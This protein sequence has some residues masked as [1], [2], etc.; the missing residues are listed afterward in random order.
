[1][2][3]KNGK[4]EEE[5]K[6]KKGRK[7]GKDRDDND[8]EKGGET[9]HYLY[10]FGLYTRAFYATRGFIYTY[11]RLMSDSF[12]MHFSYEYRMSESFSLCAQGPLNPQA[13]CA[14]FLQRPGWGLLDEEVADALVFSMPYSVI[15]LYDP[16]CLIKIN[17]R[18]TLYMKKKKN[19]TEKEGS[20]YVL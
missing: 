15:L 2:N 14:L 5:E 8:Q 6:I 11:L 16:P 3:R 7:G 13:V 17:E 20:A 9:R 12:F 10:N 1:M 19:S 18:C 4:K